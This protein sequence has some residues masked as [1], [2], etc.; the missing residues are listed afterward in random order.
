MDRALDLLAE[1]AAAHVSPG[2]DAP[3]EA[4]RRR[5][6]ELLRRAVALDETRDELQRGTL[7]EEPAPV[8]FA[9]LAGVAVKPKPK[10]SQAGAEAKA[11]AEASR[12]VCRNATPRRPPRRSSGRN[13]AGAVN[14]SFVRSS[15]APS[16][17]YGRPS[18]GSR[19]RSA[20]VRGQSAPSPRSNRSSTGFPE[21][22]RGNRSRP[23]GAAP[24]RT[25]REMHLRRSKSE[26]ARVI[27]A[28]CTRGR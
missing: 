21:Q 15:R 17:R 6:Q 24:G 28:V 2:R 18:H 23:Y 5:I 25:S 11:K 9:S 19:R 8:G 4:A 26:P 27:L 22:P 1:V 16:R 12:S 10:P 3:S 13:G 20:T 7:R 14:G